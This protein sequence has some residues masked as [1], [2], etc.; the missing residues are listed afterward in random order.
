ME[1]MGTGMLVTEHG[2]VLV[3]VVYLTEVSEGLEPQQ[4]QLQ[5]RNCFNLSHI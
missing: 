3:I 5:G 1:E 2:S 4:A